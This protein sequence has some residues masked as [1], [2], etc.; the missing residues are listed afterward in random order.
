MF[1]REEL[2]FLREVFHRRRIRTALVYRDEFFNL[3]SKER[4][5]I[6]FRFH[7]PL[8]LSM[9]ELL[10]KT[11]YKTIDAFAF[12]HCF[13]LLPDTDKPTVFYIGPY[14]AEPLS[15]QQQWLLGEKNGISPQK[16]RYL[17]EYYEGTPILAPDGALATMLSTFC[18]RL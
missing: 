6:E 1:Y 4:E 7:T 14:L 10:P 16:Q 17:S 12:C 8:P 18:E 13:F 15:H 9:P 2:S 11:V 3:L 5:E